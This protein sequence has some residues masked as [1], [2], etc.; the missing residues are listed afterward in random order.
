VPERVQALRAVE[1]LEWI[2]TPEAR[3]VLEA[4]ATGAPAARL[5]REARASLGR[6]P[7]P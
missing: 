4:L 6:L 3:K 7:A 2:G 5:T 1:V